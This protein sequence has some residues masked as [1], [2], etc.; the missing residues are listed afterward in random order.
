MSCH[1]TQTSYVLPLKAELFNDN[2]RAAQWLQKA[3]AKQNGHL[4]T[5]FI[6]TPYLNEVLSDN[7]HSDT[8]YNLFLNK[9]FPSWLYPVTQGATTIWERWNSYTRQNGFGPVR[10]NSFNHYSYGAV[11]EWMMQYTLGIKA[12]PKEPGYKHILL[13][14]QTTDRLDFVRGY[15]DT[16]YGRVS[17]RARLMWMV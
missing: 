7:G 2:A 8:A 12:D 15:Y 13:E 4:S 10:M 17:L 5:G 14:P 9:T 1:C 3:I 6:G 16:M 11:E